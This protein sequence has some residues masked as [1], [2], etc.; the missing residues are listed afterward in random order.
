MLR[1]HPSPLCYPFPTRLPGELVRSLGTDITLDNVLAIL[2]EHYNHV[3]ALDALN[4]ELFQLQM[5]KKE[6]VLDWGVHLSRHL[7]VLVV[8]FS[9]CFLLDHIAKLKHDHFYGGL[10]KRLKAMVAYLKASTN[11]KTYSDCLWAVRKAEKEEAMDPS[12]SQ[13][14]DSTSKSKVMSFFPLQKLK[15]TQPTKTPAVWVAHLEEES[16]NKEEGTESEDPNGI[17]G[18][19]EE[20]IVC[21]ARAVKDTQQEEKHCYHCSSPEHFI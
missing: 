18:V 1:S 21:L 12:C 5:G 9:E 8:S 16:A 15:G 3:K 13:T 10:P 7:Q 11:E 6:T 17:K 20:F 19:T 14:A 2:D 4:Q